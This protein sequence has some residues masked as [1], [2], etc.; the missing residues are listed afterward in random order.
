MS[1]VP[2][3]EELYDA[4]DQDHKDFIKNLDWSSQ[5]ETL[6]RFI[7]PSSEEEL[8]DTNRMRLNL[9]EMID[10]GAFDEGS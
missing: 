7:N 3:A 10:S 4:L 8:E 5:M 2:T 6:E 9:K 1:N